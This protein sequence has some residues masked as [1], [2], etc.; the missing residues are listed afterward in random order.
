[1]VPA[2]GMWRSAWSLPCELA[3]EASVAGVRQ[4]NARGDLGEDSMVTQG[5]KGS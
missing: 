4:T 3:V 1:M 2:I 5:K